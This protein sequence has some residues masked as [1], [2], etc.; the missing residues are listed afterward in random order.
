M[1]PSNDFEAMVKEVWVVVLQMEMSTQSSFF[2][3]GGDSLRAIKA[4]VRLNQ[5]FE[6]QLPVN[7][8]FKYPT[9]ISLAKYIENT[10]LSLLAEIEPDS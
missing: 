6:L 2:T 5:A 8:I 9:I 7:V 1:Q 10:V 4:V 3:I